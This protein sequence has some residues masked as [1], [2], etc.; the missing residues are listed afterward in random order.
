VQPTTTKVPPAV[1]LSDADAGNWISVVAYFPG[2]NLYGPAWATA[3]IAIWQPR[4]SVTTATGGT[5][6]YDGLPFPTSTTVAD[7]GTDGQSAT[8]PTAQNNVNAGT[9]TY[10]GLPSGVTYV[11]S[12]DLSTVHGV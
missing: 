3:R 11:T 5:K 4:P 7:G 12:P 8:Y 2:N 1:T 6:F 10:T 9:Y